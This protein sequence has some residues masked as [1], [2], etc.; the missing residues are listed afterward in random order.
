MIAP[1]M[2][3]MTKAL[4]ELVIRATLNE[5]KLRNGS[6][7]FSLHGDRTNLHLN[8]SGKFIIGGLQGDPGLTGRK[9]IIDTYGDWGAHGG[10]SV[11]FCPTESSRR[12]AV[13]L[14]VLAMGKRALSS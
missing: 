7:A 6:H 8:P 11:A 9:I 2:A 5:I 12:A 1:S 10:G 3:D 4:E 14:P 13:S